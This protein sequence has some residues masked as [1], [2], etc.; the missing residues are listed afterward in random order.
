MERE[1]QAVSVKKQQQLGVY[2]AAGRAGLQA[3][4]ERKGAPETVWEAKALQSAK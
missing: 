1:E 2:S 3:E 4:D